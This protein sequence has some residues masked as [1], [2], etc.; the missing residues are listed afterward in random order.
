MIFREKPVPKW[1]Q[2][3]RF[4]H[5]NLASRGYTKIWF[6]PKDDKIRLTVLT[7]YVKLWG[8]TLGG[9]RLWSFVEK[10]VAVDSGRLEFHIKLDQFRLFKDL[11][12]L[13]DSFETPS[14]S[15]KKWESIEHRFYGA[16]HFKH[17]EGDASWPWP[18]NRVQAHIDQ[19]GWRGF[20]DKTTT[21]KAHPKIWIPAVAHGL[22][23]YSYKDAY[24]ARRILLQ[25]G[26]DP[27]PLLGIGY[28]NR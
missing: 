25:Q 3:R 27:V 12:K 6:D 16:L 11:L 4:D 15:D 22:S 10:G 21:S 20:A 24:I 9:K 2:L 19:V 28:L 13:Y 26:F 5:A 17:F 23:Y 14:D 1:D 18:I 7:L 8:L